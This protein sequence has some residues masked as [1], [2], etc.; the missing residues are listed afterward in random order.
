MGMMVGLSSDSNTTYQRLSLQVA[1]YL[2]LVEP[3]FVLGLSIVL[4]FFLWIVPRPVKFKS[5]TTYVVSA[6]I[7]LLIAL[8]GCILHIRDH[9]TYIPD[10]NLYHESLQSTQSR[11]QA[12][13]LQISDENCEFDVMAKSK[14]KMG[15]EPY[16]YY[17]KVYQTEPTPHA[18]VRKDINVKIYVTWSDALAAIPINSEGTGKAEIQDIYG[19]I[20]TDFI[21]PFNS[22]TFS[23]HTGAAGGK[24]T[25]EE[26][27]ESL[28]GMPPRGNISLVA[29]LINYDNVS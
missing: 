10:I 14:M 11:L 17:F 25:T 26:F 2:Y 12:A 13:G 19:D 15:Q 6:I 24:M 16:N 5:H 18:F 3:Y 9:Y 22:D 27:G 4:S 7:V 20:N 28:L 29:C 21:Y 23:L 8:S 1:E